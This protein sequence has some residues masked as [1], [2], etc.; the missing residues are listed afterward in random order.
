MT[1]SK[2]KILVIGGGWHT[3]HSYAKL[4]EQLKSAGHEVHIPA[5]P[6]TN[7]SRPPSADLYSDTEHVRSIAK[8]LVDKGDELVVL[9]H[10]YGEQVG[11]NALYGLG[12][13]TRKKE[14]LAGGV[15]HLIYLT[16][17]A[18]PEGKAMIDG[19][20]HF[21]HEHLMPLAFDFAD[22]MSCVSRDPR[23]LLFGETDLPATEVDEYVASFVR[24]NGQAMYQPLNTARAAWRD[25]PVTYIHTTKD[26]TVPFDYQKWFVEEMEKEGVEVQ[27][28]TLETGHC[29]NFTAAGEV[30]NIVDQVVK[31]RLRS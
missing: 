3:P 23:T 11:T 16:A 22:D 28:A 2:P 24:W 31:G 14:G 25:I 26:M 29:A 17:Y 30:V 7:G 15:S 13:E 12:L 18:I 19:V 10:S 9:M 4:T 6:S 8:D 20:K 5:L 21:G 1:S 27:V